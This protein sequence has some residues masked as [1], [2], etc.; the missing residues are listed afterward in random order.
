[1]TFSPKSSTAEPSRHRL[2][3][4]VSWIAAPASKGSAVLDPICISEGL[5][6]KKGDAAKAAELHTKAWAA[7]SPSIN[8]AFSRQWAKKYL[9]KD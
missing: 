6:G 5:S 7:P 3:R 9:K 1:M 4:A 2:R 8:T